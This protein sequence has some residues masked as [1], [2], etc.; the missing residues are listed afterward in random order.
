MSE[1]G[2]IE[3]NAIEMGD[4]ALPTVLFVHGMAG[5]AGLWVL[6]YAFR[7]M[8]HYHVVSYDQRGHG[9]SPAPPHGYSLGEHARDL[10]RVRRRLASGPVT[11]VGYSYGG[12]VATAWAMR[13][14]ESAAALVVVDSPP[15]PV[16]AQDIDDMLDGLSAVLGGDFA[17]SGRFI[18]P[19]KDS[20][21]HDIQGRRRQIGN[22]KSRLDALRQTSF[23]HEVLADQPFSDAAFEAI[24]C[25]TALIYSS[26]AGYL[27]YAEHQ[28][29]L[30]KDCSLTIVE[31]EHDFVIKNAGAVG[32]ALQTILAGGV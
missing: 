12:H 9:L 16:A 15:L 17:P 20:L 6:A 31:G 7:L 27:G 13:Y 3:L 8:K 28:Q 18:D 29:S 11:V 2:G 25:K 4:P 23:R 21:R 1:D 30:I 19:I 10:E 14:P 24:A 5:S 32:D 26:R 22:A